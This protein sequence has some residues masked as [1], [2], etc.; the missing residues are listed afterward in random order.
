MN[1]DDLFNVIGD[2][3][4]FK[5]P[6]CKN[7]SID[8]S[9][10]QIEKQ[11]VRAEL[12]QFKFV[13]LGSTPRFE[14]SYTST[15]TENTFTLRLELP[16]HYPDQK[17]NLFIT[18]PITLR[19]SGGGRINDMGASH[20]YHTLSAGP[21]GMHSDLSLQFSVMG[22]LENMCGSLNQG[23]TLDRSLLFEPDYRPDNR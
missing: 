2:T 23:N 16:V 20:D 21:G 12:P 14:G 18:S 17:P 15:T 22:S 3:P 6:E 1:G 9:R 11:I 13:E 4:F 19:K 5:V 8:R 10:L 7:S